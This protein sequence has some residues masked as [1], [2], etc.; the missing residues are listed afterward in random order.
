MCA[1]SYGGCYRKSAGLLKRKGWRVLDYLYLCWMVKV[2][3]HPS[4]SQCI[5]E[6]ELGV[7]GV[8]DDINDDVCGE[9]FVEDVRLGD[10]GDGLYDG[11]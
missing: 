2:L 1:I 4:N 7:G 10:F 6:L 8:G 9:K 11:A 5:R 3:V